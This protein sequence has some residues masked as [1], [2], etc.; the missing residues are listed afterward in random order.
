[1]EFTRYTAYDTQKILIVMPKLEN[2]EFF[3]LLY[4][5]WAIKNPRKIIIH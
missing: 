2:V 3:A 1:M 4:F 5:I